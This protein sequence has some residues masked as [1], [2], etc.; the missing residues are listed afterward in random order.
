[1]INE[2]EK[3]AIVGDF[4]QGRSESATL[5]VAFVFGIFGLLALLQTVTVESLS[6]LILSFVY[7]LIVFGTFLSYRGW[8]WNATIADKLTKESL[9]GNK[10]I[11]DAIN[12]ERNKNF[13]TKI[14]IPDFYSPGNAGKVFDRIFI[15]ATGLIIPIMGILLWVAIAFHWDLIPK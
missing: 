6:W 14:M 2:G 5:V 10:T 1:V 7:A 11:R 13:L 4:V 9:E 15:R 12:K 8:A 3:R